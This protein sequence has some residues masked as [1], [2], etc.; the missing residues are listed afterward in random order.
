MDGNPLDLIQVAAQLGFGGVAIVILL[1]WVVP[2]LDRIA[3]R[4]G[5]LGATL[6]LLIASLP[7]VKRRTKE[8]AEELRESFESDGDQ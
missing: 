8:K 7:D 5:D 4:L 6:A 2:K 3:E 1:K